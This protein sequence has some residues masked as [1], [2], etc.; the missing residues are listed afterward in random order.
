MS[1]TYPFVLVLVT[2]TLLFIALTPNSYA[3]EKKKSKGV[4]L[5]SEDIKEDYDIIGIVSARSGE[6]VLDNLNER[7]KEE[8]KNLGADY[9]IGIRYFDYSGYIYAYGTAVKIKK[10]ETLKP[11][12]HA[13]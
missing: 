11:E 7:L 12:K 2:L 1:R 13:F 10:T 8:A 9:V 5:T 6:V 4:I 3:Q